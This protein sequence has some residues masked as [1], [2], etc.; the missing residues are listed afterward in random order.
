MFSTYRKSSNRQP[1]NLALPI[2]FGC[3]PYYRGP[4]QHVA[5]IKDTFAPSK[6]GDLFLSHGLP[7]GLPY[8]ASIHSALL[9]PAIPI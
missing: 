7:G 4:R 5:N 6:K 2:R 3:A 9:V 8:Q 1:N